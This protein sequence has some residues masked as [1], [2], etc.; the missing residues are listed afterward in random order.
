MIKVGETWSRWVHGTLRIKGVGADFGFFYVDGMAGTELN[1]RVVGNLL[2]FRDLI[3]F[4]ALLDELRKFSSSN[5]SNLFY[6]GV[7][8]A[9]FI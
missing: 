5:M 1:S 4:H 8:S 9:L 7:S 2:L 3:T 6:F